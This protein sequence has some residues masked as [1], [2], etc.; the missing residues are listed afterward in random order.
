MFILKAKKDKS[1]KRG[2]IYR[3]DSKNIQ[4][5]KYLK[6]IV[7][8]LSVFHYNAGCTSTNIVT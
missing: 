7:N 6:G 3:T 4:T 8:F 1:I 2:R 5:D